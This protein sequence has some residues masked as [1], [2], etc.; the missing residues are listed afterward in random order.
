MMVRIK[1]IILKT[2]IFYYLYLILK[3]ANKSLRY[4]TKPILTNA[5]LKTKQEYKN[6][7]NQ[8][9]SLGLIPHI[10]LA[11]NWDSLS[12]LSIILKLTN[13]NASILDGGGVNCTL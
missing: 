13:K 2:R 8:V 3:G 1:E 5:V 6:A 4:P 7:L 11:K 12:A 10:E 9:K